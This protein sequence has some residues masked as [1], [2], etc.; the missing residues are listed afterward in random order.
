MYKINTL[1]GIRA[2]ELGLHLNQSKSELICDDMFSRNV[3]LNDA[4]A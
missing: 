3:M 1:S 4:P 2:A